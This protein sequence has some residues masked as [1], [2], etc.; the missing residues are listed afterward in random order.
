[1]EFEEIVHL[2]ET[3]FLKIIISLLKSGQLSIDEAKKIVREFLGLLPF[4]NM[5]D[6]HDK[7]KAFT[8][9]HQEFSSVYITL[10]KLRDEEKAMELVTDMKQLIKDNKI[11]EALAL[12]K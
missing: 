8:S 2:I 10:L 9:N 7:L 12:V 6:L 5:G 4:V 1:M 3:D 11:D